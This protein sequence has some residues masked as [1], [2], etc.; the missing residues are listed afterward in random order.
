MLKLQS[1]G[2]NDFGQ[3]PT[4]GFLI[5]NMWHALYFVKSGSGSLTIR[6]NT[7]P[8]KKGDF[9]FI[10]P[11]EPVRYESRPADPVCYYW[12]A[13]YPE[14]AE[15]ISRIM[16]F[17]QADPVHEANR[18]QRA[19]RLLESLLESPSATTETYFTALSVL[20][21][22]LTT[23]VSKDS[24][25][26]SGARQEE[27]VRNVKQ[28][29]LLNYT[30]P[31][32]HIEAIAHLLF[33]SHAHMTRVFKEATGITPV[34]YLVEQRLIHASGLLRQSNATI[35]EICE[36]SGFSDEWHFMK[37]FKKKYGMTA[38]EYRREGV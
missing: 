28:L 35:R 7:Y 16:G 14:F 21:Q 23:E 18:P 2:Y 33:V 34:A 26:R 25:G 13:F 1:I 30:N 10:T 31:E 5:T 12:F 4:G 15:E 6:D 8:L 19:E 37:C 29:V 38:K 3:K 22:L 17:T 11:N 20:M 32:F 9:Y 36:A 24:G 27:L